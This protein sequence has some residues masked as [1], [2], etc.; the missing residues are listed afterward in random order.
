MIMIGNMPLF[1]QKAVFQLRVFYTFVYTHELK[2]PAQAIF[3]LKTVQ[4]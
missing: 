3:P 2:V 1:S 4:D